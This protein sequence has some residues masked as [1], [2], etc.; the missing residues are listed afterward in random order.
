MAGSLRVCV[1]SLF[2]SSGMLS[3]LGAILEGHARVRVVGVSGASW[4]NTKC[5]YFYPAPGLHSCWCETGSSTFACEKSW[6]QPCIHDPNQQCYVDYYCASP[7][8][9]YYCNQATLHCGNKRECALCTTG[10]WGVHSDCIETD[11]PCDKCYG[12]D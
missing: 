10:V 6:P 11:I 2:V 7:Y 1:R 5:V 8:V 4:E 12:C 3:I 9:G